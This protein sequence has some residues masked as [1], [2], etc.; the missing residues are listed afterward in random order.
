MS[1]ALDLFE[2]LGIIR[3]PITKARTRGPLETCCGPFVDRLI[4]KHGVGHAAF[5]LKSI[6]ETNGNEHE[7]IADVIAAI[8][9]I[10]VLHPRWADLGGAWLDAFDKIKLADIRKTAQASRLQPLRLAISTILCL[11]LEEILGPSALPKPPKITKP[12]PEPKPP[13]TL[14]RIPMIETNIKLGMDLLELRT[15]IPH[16]ASFGHAIRRQFDVDAKTAAEAMKVARLYGGR[17][18][19]FT[20]LSWVALVALSSPTLSD[21]VRAGLEARIIAGEKIGA[22]EIRRARGPQRS[23][24]PPATRRVIGRNHKASMAA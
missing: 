3:V 16:N 24:R 11:R 13:G 6:A 4:K 5:V 14:M 7:L 1:A 17:P 23:G 22:P 18:A 10:V 19:I 9:D 12:K 21:A 20:R 2:Q 8:S 15:N